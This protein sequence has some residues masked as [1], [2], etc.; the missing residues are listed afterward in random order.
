MLRAVDPA[1]G[2]GAHGRRGERMGIRMTKKRIAALAACLAWWQ[3]PT[4]LAQDY[5]FDW[6]T[7]GDPGNPAYDDPWGGSI[8]GRGSVGYEYRIGRYEV[9]TGQWM[10]FVNTFSTQS[11]EFTHFA[12]PIFW[13]AEPDPTYDGP[14]RR[15]RLRS[16]VT[17]PEMLPVGGITWREAAMFCNW[18]HN[19]QSYDLSAIED[20]AYD[21][22]TFTKNSDGTFND[23]R[24]HHPD[25]RFWIPTLDEWVKAAHYD[26]DRY[27]E[28]EAG[29]WEYSITS[30]E[31]PI[32]APPGEG[33]ANAGFQLSDW[34]EWDIPL[35]AYPG[36]LSPWG[37]LDAAGGT[38]EWTEEV[39]FDDHP[40]NRA[41]EGSYAGSEAPIAEIDDR[42]SRL[43]STLPPWSAGHYEGLRIVGLV[44]G[45]ATSFTFAMTIALGRGYRRRS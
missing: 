15:W 41:L 13:G 21:T 38:M 5:G 8:D 14:G 40:N 11:D 10:E 39:F 1:T 28:G 20:G 31:Q 4:G 42:A 9:T 12:D 29:W 37:L 23:Q 36:V 34:A 17:T 35:G 19:G 30:D 33:Q 32:Y 44:P 22:S 43:G 26:P 18:L 25:A 45:P 24:T 16:G 7:I 27:G 2:G 3:V 6:V